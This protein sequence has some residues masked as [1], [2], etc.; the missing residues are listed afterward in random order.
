MDIRVAKLFIIKIFENYSILTKLLLIVNAVRKF[1]VM[2]C[3]R[4]RATRYWMEDFKMFLIRRTFSKV[5]RKNV[6]IKTK[7][8]KKCILKRLSKYFVVLL[9]AIKYIYVNWSSRKKPITEKST[10]VR[11]NYIGELE[12]KRKASKVK[13]R[14]FYE[15]STNFSWLHLSLDSHC[16]VRSQSVI[17]RH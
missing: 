15:Q 2:S 6:E 7:L 3:W 9:K 13:L 17:T 5:A 8:S 14:K 1:F 11:Q 12:R 16:L 4:K 10:C